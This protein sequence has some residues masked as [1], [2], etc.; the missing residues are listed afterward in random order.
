[1]K[2]RAVRN[3]GVTTKTESSIS[4]PIVDFKN[5]FY[6]YPESLNRPRQQYDSLLVWL[7]IEKT[8]TPDTLINIFFVGIRKLEFSTLV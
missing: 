4:S 6:M 2:D 8:L 3:I 7:R 5:P 1:M